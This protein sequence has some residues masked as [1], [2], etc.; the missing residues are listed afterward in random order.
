MKIS[1][2]AT[3]RRIYHVFQKSPNS[4]SVSRLN[5]LGDRNFSQRWCPGE[6]IE[7]SG[8]SPTVFL[9]FEPLFEWRM[10]LFV[11]PLENPALA[12][13]THWCRCDSLI[14]PCTNNFHCT[15]HDNTSCRTIPTYR[16]IITHSSIS[17]YIMQH[18]Y[19]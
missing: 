17:H 6:C 15:I 10:A 18:N 2:I 12:N 4:M 19:T 11:P 7:R 16:V 13:R 9:N 14:P 1:K 5:F 3:F 8:K